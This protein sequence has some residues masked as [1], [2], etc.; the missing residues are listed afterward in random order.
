MYLRAG[1]ILLAV[2]AALVVGRPS[3]DH[4]QTKDRD[5]KKD[6]I[7]RSKKS[8]HPVGQGECP[9]GWVDGRSAQ[10]YEKFPYL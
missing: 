8:F 10:V 2:L 5:L 7:M 1:L 3:K 4:R 6:V 9:E